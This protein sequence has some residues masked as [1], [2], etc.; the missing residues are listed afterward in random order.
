MKITRRNLL[1]ASAATGLARGQS[2]PRT[3][4]SRPVPGRRFTKE[5]LREIA[6]PLGGIG[7]GTVSLGGRGNLHDWEIVNRPA[8]GFT[9]TNCKPDFSFWQVGSRTVWSPASSLDIGLDLLYNHVDTAFAG[10]VAVS[11]NGTV[12]AG[13]FNAT[14]QGVLSGALR[15]QRNFVP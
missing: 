12:P 1:A 2:S 11:A 9:P 7:T 6:F 14:G 15:I 5:S 10:P 3:Q 13:L 4:G 8:K